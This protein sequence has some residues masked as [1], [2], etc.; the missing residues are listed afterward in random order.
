MKS[1]NEKLITHFNTRFSLELSRDFKFFEAAKDEG[2]GVYR[3]KLRTCV[4]NTNDEEFKEIPDDLLLSMIKRL[5]DDLV[6]Q[7]NNDIIRNRFW[8]AIR[9]AMSRGLMAEED[10]RTKFNEVNKLD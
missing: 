8:D 10:A 4:D 1:I 3:L 5:Q 7:P 9:H 6:T 2:Q